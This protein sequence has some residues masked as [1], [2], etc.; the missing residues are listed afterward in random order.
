MYTV[1]DYT[2]KTAVGTYDNIQEALLLV[3]FYEKVDRDDGEYTPDR[4]GILYMSE[5][6]AN[7]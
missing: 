1:Y 5:E 3:D 4:Y 2:T 6:E 7:A